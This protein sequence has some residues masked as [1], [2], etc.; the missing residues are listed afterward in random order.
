VVEAAA[1]AAATA[2]GNARLSRTRWRRRLRRRRWRVQR[3]VGRALWC[4]ARADAQARSTP[5]WRSVGVA[6]LRAVVPRP[7]AGARGRGGG[8][9]QRRPRGGCLRVGPPG[10]HGVGGTRRSRAGGG[11]DGIGC[12]AQRGGD[13]SSGHAGADGT[14]VVATRTCAAPNGS[15]AASP[16]SKR[17]KAQQT[18]SVDTT[19]KM[20]GQGKGHRETTLKQKRETA[21]PTPC[22]CETAVPTGMS[23]PPDSPGAPPLPPPPPSPPTA[24]PPAAFSIAYPPRPHN[25]PGGRAGRLARTRRP[26]GRRPSTAAAPQR[27]PA[28][29]APPAPHRVGSR[30]R[31]GHSI[32]GC[33][34]CIP[35]AAPIPQWSPQ[36]WQAK[37]VR[38]VP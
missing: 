26:H 15:A 31:V 8:G 32:W 6:P 27:A 2:G 13:T 9:G 3:A 18:A 16:K 38:L 5:R 37:A 4:A 29:P 28:R 22:T 30:Y 12:A 14:N 23:V 35:R 10:R 1:A 17:R 33:S 36:H 19:P 34:T 11:Q 7:R 20:F 25:A 24:A 21:Q